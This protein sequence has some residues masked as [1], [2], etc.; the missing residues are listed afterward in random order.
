MHPVRPLFVSTYPPEECGLATF[1]KDSAD[2]VDL[3]AR[4]SVSSVAAIQKTQTACC[5]DPRVVHV[6]DN[7]CWDAYQMAAEVANDGPC[8]VVSLQHEFGLYPGEWGDR[9]L[10]FVAGCRKPIVTTFHTLMT[11]P[12]PVPRRLI[13]ILASH[14]Q[15][16]VVMT[17]VAAQLLTMVY[18]VP[19]SRVRVIPHGVPVV[20]FTC[21]D[22]QKSRL[23]LADRQVICTF[24][25]INR[26]KGL[27]SMLRAMPRIVA[28]VPDAMYLIVGATHPQVRLQEGE[29]YRE[30]LAEMAES[31]GVGAHVRFVNRYLSLPELLRHLQACDV[32][33]TPYPGMDQ[34]A[35]G[36]MAYALGA[37]GAVV[38]TPYLYAQEVL[39]EGRGSLVPFA[40]SAAL[41]GATLRFLR[42]TVFR[43]ETKRRAYEYAKPMFWPHVGRQYL[44]LFRHAASARET[45][46]EQVHCGTSALRVG[47]VRPER[48]GFRSR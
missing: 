35:S 18:H 48:F 12:A 4:E 7:G 29:I 37:V 26:G 15:G 27:E 3:A 43:L 40:D 32:F 16:V 42:D 11:Q 13:Q 47:L 34:I 39:A 5:D 33:V 30:S 22:S 6:I 31:L 14:S 38:S 23:G 20:P 46:G 8:D 36:T 2:A 25:L 9:I 10:D 1:T 41:A 21:D 19:A 28:A 17:K 44:D 24:G 45:A